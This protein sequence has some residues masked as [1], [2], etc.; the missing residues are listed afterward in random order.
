[1]DPRYDAFFGRLLAE[2][3][4]R[5][6]EALLGPAA[7]LSFHQ[8][9]CIGF[10]E[11][12]DTQLRVHTD[13]SDLTVNVLLGHGPGGAHSG[14]ELVLLAPTEEDTRCGSPRLDGSYR[15]KT[16]TYRHAEVGRAV[17]HS[18]ERWHAVRPLRAGA[19]SNLIIWAMRN[20]CDWKKG[21][22]PRWTATSTRRPRRR[23]G[24]GPLEGA[25]P[26]GGAAARRRAETCPPRGGPARLFAQGAEA[27][28]VLPSRVVWFKQWRSGLAL[29]IGPL[30]GVF[31]SHSSWSAPL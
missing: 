2:V 18:G 24:R 4:R 15:G 8:D 26:V 6:D 14:A 20:D 17:V 5:V 29:P 7:P 11:G 30:Q 25:V 19:R 27:F 9:Y 3:L 28:S 23:L 22:Y 13:D 21:F 12:R 31:S 16:Y 10:A 1:M